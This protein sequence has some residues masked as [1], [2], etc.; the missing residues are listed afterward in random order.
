MEDRWQESDHQILKDG[1]FVF[2]LWSQKSREFL[3]ENEGKTD[4]DRSTARVL[5]RHGH[6]HAHAHGAKINTW[7]MTNDTAD[8]RTLLLVF[9]PVTC[10]PVHLCTCAPWPSRK[11]KSKKAD[12]IRSTS[13]VSTKHSFLPNEKKKKKSNQNK[14]GI[15]FKTRVNKTWF[16]ESPHECEQ[17]NGK[18]LFEIDP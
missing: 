6:A 10:A 15:K 1:C 7:N 18:K 12:W 3:S 5:G 9:K 17:R 14:E 8:S 13:M 2:P 16:T 11:R 4:Q